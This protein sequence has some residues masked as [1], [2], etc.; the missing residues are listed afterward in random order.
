M[1]IKRFIA[2]VLLMSMILV[3]MSVSAKDM[4]GY[5][6]LE[7]C[8]TNENIIILNNDIFNLVYTQKT[9]DGLYRIVEHMTKDLKNVESDFYKLNTNTNE[10]VFVKHRTSNVLDGKLLVDIKENGITTHETYDIVDHYNLTNDAT[11]GKGSI[12]I[13]A[14]DDWHTGYKSGDSYIEN[15]TIS[16]TIQCLGT[17]IGGVIGSVSG[18][19][20]AGAVTGNYLGNIAEKIVMRGVNTVYYEATVKWRYSYPYY[21]YESTTKFYDEDGGYL[22]TSYDEDRLTIN[23]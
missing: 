12:S 16:A 11:T 9:D 19:P 18:H 2:L 5:D 23:M 7:R 4:V 17:L 6:T 21:D 14:Y 10:F 8:C 13:N 3:P 20:I 15:A 1:N 22:G